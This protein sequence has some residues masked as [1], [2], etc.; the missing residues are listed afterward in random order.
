MVQ[1]QLHSQFGPNIRTTSIPAGPL[2]LMFSYFAIQNFRLQFDPPLRG[3][4]NKI[5]NR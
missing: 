2:L 5:E 3:P 1:G 4:L